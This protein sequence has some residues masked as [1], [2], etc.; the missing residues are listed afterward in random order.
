MALLGL[1][2]RTILGSGPKQFQEFFR[3]GGQ[4][5]NPHGRENERRHDKQ[6]VTHR[7]GNYLEILGN[8][9]LG[10]ADVYNLLP[11]DIVTAPD[12]HIFQQRLQKVL[13]ENAKGERP[14]WQNMF[15]PRLPIYAHPLRRALQIGKVDSATNVQPGRS[16]NTCINGW[17]QFAQ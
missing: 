10:L 17:L 7:T 4:T 2:H 6:L 11:A 8:S 3:L 15:S 1:I 14:G 5:R 16:D 12:V 9:I 13:I